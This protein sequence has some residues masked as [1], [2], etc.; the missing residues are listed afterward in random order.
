MYTF[1]L[2][3]QKAL[4]NW[5]QA[6][7]LCGLGLLVVALRW[8]SYPLGISALLFTLNTGSEKNG[9]G[10]LCDLFVWRRRKSYG[11]GKNIWPKRAGDLDM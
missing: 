10:S 3:T 9:R 1:A 4:L 8:D 2:N 6:L 11:V 7:V 5:R